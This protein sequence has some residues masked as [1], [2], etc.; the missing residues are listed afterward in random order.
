MSKRR[1]L[2][3][4]ILAGVLII[5]SGIFVWAIK[6]GRIAPKAATN[7]VKMKIIKG[8]T[9]PNYLNVS[10][11][12]YATIDPGFSVNPRYHLTITPPGTGCVKEYNET[13]CEVR[14]EE[15]YWDKDLTFRIR[16]FYLNDQR[17]DVYSAKFDE[18]RTVKPNQWLGGLGDVEFVKGNNPPPFSIDPN[19]KSITINWKPLPASYTKIEVE[20]TEDGVVVKKEA[21]SGTSYT[22]KP[23]VIGK[24]YFL[25]IIATT[26]AGTISTVT[27]TEI[28][29][30]PEGTIAATEEEKSPCE[31]KQSGGLLSRF[32]ILDLD[33][34]GAI[35]NLVCTFFTGVFTIIFKNLD[36]AIVELTPNLDTIKTAWGVVNKLISIPIA[37]FIIIIAFANI[38]R[39]Q[40]ENFDIRRSLI[41]LILG[42][43]LANL[44]FV[45]AKELLLFS[46][47]LTDYFKTLTFTAVNPSTPTAAAKVYNFSNE[48]TPKLLEMFAGQ[49]IGGMF[50]IALFLVVVLLVF[51]VLLV[52]F[53]IRSYAIYALVIIAP[54]A[55]I[56]FM[57]PLTKDWG[58]KWW[59]NFF[60]WVFLAPITMFFISLGS[61]IVGSPTLTIVTEGTETEG[62]GFLA[63]LII[64]S[65]FISMGLYIPLMMGGSVMGKAMGSLS[66]LGKSIGGVVGKKVKTAAKGAAAERLEAMRAK[67]G[68]AGKAVQRVG[69]MIQKPALSLAESE[70]KAKT[71][72][73]G[74]QGTRLDELEAKKKANELTN[75]E[76]NR[77]DEL[78]AKGNLTTNEQ[79][80]LNQLKEKDKG[81][82]SKDQLE[83]NQLGLE[84]K[85]RESDKYTYASDDPKKLE[86]DIKDTDAKEARGEKLSEV[87]KNMRSANL[88]KYQNLMRSELEQPERERMRQMLEQ[89]SEKQPQKTVPGAIAVKKIDPKQWNELKDPNKLAS[90]MTP[91]AQNAA[92][93]NESEIRTFIE[94]QISAYPQAQQENTAILK[95]LSSKVP[96]KDQAESDRLANVVGLTDREK[97]LA[98]TSKGLEVAASFTNDADKANALKKMNESDAEK[99]ID[100]AT[101]K[102]GSYQ[103]LAKNAETISLNEQGGAGAALDK[104]DS[105]QKEIEVRISERA[106]VKIETDIKGRAQNVQGRILDMKIQRL[107]DFIKEKDLTKRQQMAP[108]VLGISVTEAANIKTIS[109]FDTMARYQKDGANIIKQNLSNSQTQTGMNNIK[110]QFKTQTEHKIALKDSLKQIG[111]AN[112]VSLTAP[113]R[114]MTKI[115]KHGART[116]LVRALPTINKKYKGDLVK[117]NQATQDFFD[118]VNDHLKKNNTDLDKVQIGELLSDPDLQDNLYNKLK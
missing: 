32:K 50:F 20:T 84:R 58:Q 69:E 44:S 31:K 113:V 36:A 95:D 92:A 16:L 34:G 93:D 23:Y 14:I 70:A 48:L 81:L 17:I 24:K 73:E 28:M 27:T 13:N 26:L 74:I 66:K 77:K 96:A 10:W 61:I 54:L 105:M 99:A 115:N 100:D 5:A 108:S 35:Q 116:A 89:R 101:G 87:E 33:I 6:S 71:L 47:S 42:V 18:S 40:I 7:P 97:G 2:S 85:K 12:Y 29:A 56:L 52:V 3:L 98:R 109:K 41:N 21:A 8:T 9:G 45:I 114:K 11:D 60:K 39:I 82:N 46:N 30:T 51:L 65:I 72:K 110:A 104:L 59:S 1:K 75:Q 90:Q 25:K 67:G 83:Y 68:L 62:T 112:Q 117:Q 15:S 80:E 38:L 103:R 86:Q 102:K 55:Q 64:F 111:D 118:T 88:R 106:I 76:K 22:Y 91:E 78:T 49:T 37:I 19:T 79:Q 4:L 53:F 107:Q 94:H 63:T 57:F 43:I